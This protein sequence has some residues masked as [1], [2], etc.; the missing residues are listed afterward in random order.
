MLASWFHEWGFQTVPFGELLVISM[1]HGPVMKESLSLNVVI[2][3]DKQILYQV[4]STDPLQTNNLGLSD[5]HIS[6]H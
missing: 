2:R 4:P 1:L 3:R 6:L 5:I